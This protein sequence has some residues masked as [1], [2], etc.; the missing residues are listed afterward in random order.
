MISQEPSIKVGILDHRRDVNGS[1]NGVF[2]IDDSRQLQGT[3][4]AR[5]D[6]GEIV[7][8]TTMEI[9]PSLGKRFNVL[10]SPPE[11]SHSAMSRLECNFIGKEGKNRHSGGN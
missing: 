8:S 1:F 3:F 11:H 10:M 6:N 7:L 4:R 2:A 9:S 5:C